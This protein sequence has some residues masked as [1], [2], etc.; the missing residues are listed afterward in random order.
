MT[1]FTQTFTAQEQHIDELGHVNNAIWVQWIQD[2]ATAH[3]GSIAPEEMQQRYIWM[4]TR[5]E[6]DYRGN[7]A[8]G[9]SVTG[10]T[11]ISD[12]PR[13]AR[14]NRNVAFDNA[15]GKTIV[16]AI[17]SWALLDRQTQKLLRVRDDITGIFGL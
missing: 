1:P 4:V 9:E 11:W 16:T 6:I 7:I 3:W 10:R 15:G 5:H 13:G 17:T 14:F 2:I 12:P 8:L